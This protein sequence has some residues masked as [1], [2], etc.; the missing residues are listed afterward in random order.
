MS[1]SDK[2]AGPPGRGDRTI[3]RP[4]PGARRPAAPA[5]P[6]APAPSAGG[7]SYPAP[8]APGAPPSSEDWIST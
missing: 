8:P 6:S 7:V 5:V 1:D 4:N 3:I 2:P